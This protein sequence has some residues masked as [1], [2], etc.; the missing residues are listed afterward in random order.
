MTKNDNKEN[1][2]NLIVENAKSKE[3]NSMYLLLDIPIVIFRPD[4][5]RPSVFY[6]ENV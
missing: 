1:N 3:P 2:D 4:K 5:F 6:T